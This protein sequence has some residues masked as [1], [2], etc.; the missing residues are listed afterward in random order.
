MK[1]IEEAAKEYS[2]IVVLKETDASLTEL[3]EY[4]QTDFKAGVE[5][6]QR[7]IPVE[8]E[9]PNPLPRNKSG[10]I[11]NDDLLLLKYIP[12]YSLEFGVLRELNGEL[13]WEIPDVGNAPLAD[14][15]HWRPI[16][17]K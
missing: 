7:W 6:A 15:T 13:Y 1:T 3:K 10:I 12:Y 14:V 2:E 5:F 17:L 8:E 16:E 11:D 4:A 9:L